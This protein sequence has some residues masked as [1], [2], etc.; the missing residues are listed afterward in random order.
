M[1]K[2]FKLSASDI[3]ELVPGMGYCI[4]TD[5]ITVEGKR[6]G[7]L[8]R[9]EP[10]KKDDSGWRFFSGDESQEY[11]DEPD[12]MA[13]Y[14]VNTIANY[15]PDIIPLL[16][17]PSGAAFGRDPETGEFVREAFRPADE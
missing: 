10:D 16:G 2:K 9:E 1:E 15:D 5:M 17:S 14:A 6:V 4:A 3:R 8:Y 7:Y 12:N 13:I 11:V